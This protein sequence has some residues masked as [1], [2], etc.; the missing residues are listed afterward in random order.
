MHFVNIVKPRPMMMEVIEELYGKDANVDTD[1]DS[2]PADSMEWTSLWIRKRDSD[3]PP[4]DIEVCTHSSW[5]KV[6][7]DDIAQEELIALYL[8]SNAGD[9]IRND[10]GDLSEFDI[11]ALEVRVERGRQ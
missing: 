11:R 4:V 6:S 5:F 1:G 2:N 7:S 9:K 8:Y 3:L 10:Q